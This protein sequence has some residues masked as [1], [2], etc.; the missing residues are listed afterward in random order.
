MKDC[1]YPRFKSDIDVTE[2]DHA[3]DVFG[4]RIECEVNS[5]YVLGGQKIWKQRV[6]EKHLT[7]PSYHEAWFSGYLTLFQEIAINFL[8]RTPEETYNLSDLVLEYLQYI[9]NERMPKSGA[10]TAM[11]IP[12]KTEESKHNFELKRFEIQ[13][14]EAVGVPTKLEESVS[15]KSFY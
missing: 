10:A 9:S 2:F 5:D 7:A 8:N 15:K 12:V 13:Q 1:L 11:N 4:I 14:F 3:G 6:V